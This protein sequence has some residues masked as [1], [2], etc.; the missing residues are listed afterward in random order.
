[1]KQLFMNL[2]LNAMTAI[3]SAG[4][5]EVAIEAG[6]DRLR[7]TVRDTGPGVPP[8]ERERIFEPFVSLREGGTGLGLA[9]SRRI[10]LDHGG[11]IRC[12]DTDRGALFVVELPR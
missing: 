8:A 12:A 10:A 7:A 2:L 3:G 6:T 1:M 5:I 11:S 9:V 4:R